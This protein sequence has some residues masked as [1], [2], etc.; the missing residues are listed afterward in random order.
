MALRTEQVQ[1]DISFITD[2]SKAFA[3]TLLAT[4][5]L[6]SEIDASRGKL[7]NYRKQLLKVGDD[8][9]KRAEI[10]QKIAAEE[11]N[12][13]N[14][15]T[16]IGT[17]AK[18]VEK[19]D[20]SKLTP[21]QLTERMKQLQQTMRHMSQTHPEF[22][23][24]KEEFDGIDLHVKSLKE[25]SL[26]LAVATSLWQQ[27]FTVAVGVLGGLSL[28]NLLGS[29]ATYAEKLFG[30]GIAAESMV[31]KTQ[32]VFGQAE[33]IVRDFAANTA[34]SIGLSQNEFVRF[35][36]DIGDLLVPMGFTQDAAAQLSS[37]LVKQGGV[38]SEWS[39]GK[40]SAAEATEILQ[41]SLLGERDALNS[42][43]IDIKQEL[44]DA[45]LRRLGQDK[46]TGSALRQAEAMATLNLI[47]A[48]STAANQ[49]FEKNADSLVRKKAELKAKIAEITDGLSSGLIPA[50]KSLLSMGLGVLNVFVAVGGGLVG[51]T[52]II[53]DNRLAFLALIFAL[54]SFNAELIKSRALLIWDATAKARAAIAN[55]VLTA[56]Q[57][58]L[59][60][61]MSANPIGVIITAL[62][63]LAIGFSEAYKRSEN[64]RAGIAGL[65]A[66]VG[67]LW[68]IIKEV[69]GSFVQGFK[70]LAEGDFANAGKSFL[71]VIVKT[72]P[73][74]LAYT[75]GARL[76]NAYKKGFRD[77]KISAAE[78]AQEANRDAAENEADDRQLATPAQGK[79]IKKTKEE[80]EKE[81]KE[82][83]DAGQKVIENHNARRTLQLEQRRQAENLS[84][85]QFQAAQLEIQ[86]QGLEEQLQLLRRYKGAN[87]TET[88]D[89]QTKLIENERALQKA[90][91]DAAFA[92]QPEKAQS[93]MTPDELAADAEKKLGVKR[94]AG[95]AERQL[96]LDELRTKEHDMSDAARREYE[97][98]EAAAEARKKLATD[99][100]EHKKKLDEEEQQRKQKQTD[101]GLAAAGQLFGGIAELLGKDDAARKKHANK[102][103]AL[104]KAEVVTAG[105]AEVQKIWA[106]S[107]SFGPFGFILA[108]I[109]TAVA[110]ART[111]A[112]IQKIEATKFATG[113]YTGGGFGAADSTGFRRAGI[114]HEGE[115]VVPKWQVDD[116]RFAPALGILEGHRMRGYA[117]GGFVGGAT[118]PQ[119]AATSAPT[120][121]SL[122][123]S[124]LASVVARFEQAVLAMPREVKARVAYTDI[125]DAGAT[126][127]SIRSDAAL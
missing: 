99:E 51:A 121:G 86:R 114:V 83:L 35:A 101:A 30:M 46:L 112:A 48:Q 91:L 119:F 103:K 88:L 106:N 57:W 92:P 97:L 23:K 125:E 4:K 40:V 81:V 123:V 67:E 19:I 73:I 5:E 71:N 26:K 72:N 60:A 21:A 79:G 110:V 11:K 74:G 55:A 82:A 14:N 58:R 17:A 50:F 41:K 45:E 69:F 16:K 65:G 62:S 127:N 49:R 6:N 13:A 122:D 31:T 18:S 116:H 89:A 22:K 1:L 117:T 15:M 64:F 39:N 75:E 95:D 98:A 7:E 94:E 37:E 3:K 118:S 109:Q 34:Q 76:G 52:K 87:A 124:G 77:S 2:E 102:I 33:G 105:I 84:E 44:V 78:L 8:E 38:L 108:G 115:Y 20:L 66:V 107:A 27:A 120:S 85:Q 28:D 80:I 70:S 59:N 68:T 56:S 25:N 10:L 36:T 12:V 61:A 126:L 90:R 111:A 29:L 113:G 9:T 42:L 54:A 100:A 96:H 104:Q 63:L 53:W 32:T 93:D 43:G 24:M 47:Y